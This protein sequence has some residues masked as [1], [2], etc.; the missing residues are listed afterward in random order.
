MMNGIPCIIL[1]D[2][3]IWSEKELKQE[4]KKLVMPE[5]F[6]E[7]QQSKES[8]YFKNALEELK[9]KFGEK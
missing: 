3:I 8:N 7:F 5:D 1:E 6:T 2:G 9:K 4:S